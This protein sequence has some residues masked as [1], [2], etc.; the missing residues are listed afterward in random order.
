MLYYEIN[1]ETHF[2]G[3]NMVTDIELIRSLLIKIMKEDNEVSW[4]DIVPRDLSGQDR[5]KQLKHIG[6]LN[7]NELIKCVSQPGFGGVEHYFDIELASKGSDLIGVIGNEK[8]W[9]ILGE[10]KYSSLGALITVA[11]SHQVKELLDKV[12]AASKDFE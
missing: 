12:E 10:E 4:Q 5:K 3:D 1:Y 6:I 8:I 9:N 2:E 7:D 11:N